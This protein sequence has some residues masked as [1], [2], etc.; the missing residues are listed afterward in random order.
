MK[1]RLESLQ[2]QL[3]GFIIVPFSLLL[4]GI[5]ILGINIHNDAM[6]Q[7]VA[8]RD[9]RAV[10]ANAAA[11][12][13]RLHHREAA[14]AGLSFRL[15]DGVPAEDVLGDAQ[16][17][18]D[19]FDGGLAAIGEDGLIIT[20]TIPVENWGMTPV[21]ELVAALEDNQVAYS[22]PYWQS[23]AAYVLIGA[24][25]RDH[26]AV[27]SFSIENIVPQSFAG[28]DDVSDEFSTILIDSSG[29]LLF[30]RGELSNQGN[31]LQHP[32]IQA[33][34]RGEMGS[35]YLPAKD[36]EHV[37]AFSRIEPTEWSLIIEEPWKSVASPLLDISLAAPLILVPALLATSIAL[38]FG[39]RKIIQP[40]RMLE[41]EASRLAEADYEAIEVPVGGIAEIERLQQTLI[42]MTH[43]IRTAQEA[44]QSYVGAVTNAQEEERKRLA[45]ELHDE[46]IQDLIVIAQRIQVIGRDLPEEG[47]SAVKL[48]ALR[49]E[50]LR[51]ISEIRRLVRALRPMYI[52]DLGLIPA[53]EM[54]TT[55][56]WGDF[57]I[58]V[59]I[60]VSGEVARL[61][62]DIELA[63]YRVVQESLSNMGRHAHGTRASIEI[64]FSDA[65]FSIKISDD[66]KGFL[67]PER[68]TDFAAAGHYGLIGMYE[69][70][71]VIGATLIIRSIPEKGTTVL[72]NLPSNRQDRSRDPGNPVN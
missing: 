1:I 30:G 40:L 69:R 29:E 59:E 45:R 27:G 2:L 43:R 64:E 52:D 15:N 5:A 67:L 13:E 19:D 34:L 54:L 12:S 10:R 56:F 7:L 32:G 58:P 17:L 11:I 3:L 37:V 63:I 36:G 14:L 23:D 66:G 44:L 6:R 72:L 50:V 60:E 65:G 41:E 61:G 8:E 4:L 33:A 24:R 21:L 26:A 68:H 49:G 47:S 38:W 53:L 39:A 71:E 35:S 31:L 57:D 42:L 20:S 28:S 22:D 70:A 16:F 55:D 25:I 62:P 48:E 46:T 18:Y 9:E 51:A